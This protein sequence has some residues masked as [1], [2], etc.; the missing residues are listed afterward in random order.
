MRLRWP[1]GQSVRLQRW[2][3]WDRI[4]DI[5]LFVVYFFRSLTRFVF[6]YIFQIILNSM[7]RLF[8]TIMSHIKVKSRASVILYLNCEGFGKESQRLRAD[9]NPELALL[10][11]SKTGEGVTHFV[12]SLEN[13]YYSSSINIDLN[14]LLE[15]IYLAPS[16]VFSVFLSDL[17]NYLHHCGVCAFLDHRYWLIYLFAHYMMSKFS[18]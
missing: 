2:I 12:L 13:Y 3:L 6:L 16:S 14:Y 17:K 7:Q 9:K 8:L 11:S 18:Y 5:K 10:N 4:P 15:F 1:N